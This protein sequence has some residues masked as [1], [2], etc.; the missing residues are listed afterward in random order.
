MRLFL[1]YVDEP[2]ITKIQGKL[3]VQAVVPRKNFLLGIIFLVQEKKNGN[4][5]SFHYTDRN[6]YM[7]EFI[8]KEFS[9]SCCLK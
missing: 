6:V 3:N 4:W 1:K 8:T 2:Q 9:G 7:Y 5:N